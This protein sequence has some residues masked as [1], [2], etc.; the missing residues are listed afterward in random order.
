MGSFKIIR[1]TGKN[2]LRKSV[3]SDIF[4]TQTNA[5]FSKR[6]FY[7]V[8]NHIKF[9]AEID[10]LKRYH[11]MRTENNTEY[12]AFTKNN[13][14]IDETIYPEVYS[15][16]RFAW[17][18]MNENHVMQKKMIDDT[19]LQL[20]LNSIFDEKELK[21]VLGENYY[22][23]YGQTDKEFIPFVNFSKRRG[24]IKELA[25]QIKEFRSSNITVQDLKEIV[26]DEQSMLNSLE[27]KKKIRNLTLVLAFVDE[28]LKQ[29]NCILDC[30]LLDQFNQLLQSQ[31][32]EL[33]KNSLIYL[34]GFDD[35]TQAEINIIRQLIQK[36]TQV[37]LAQLHGQTNQAQNP[38]Y[39]FHKPDKMLAKIGMKAD[40]YEKS[41]DLKKR[42]TIQEYIE[43]AWRQLESDELANEELTP[44]Q[45]T[46]YEDVFFCKAS[47]K[48]AEIEMVARTIIKN[49]SKENAPE[50]IRYKDILIISSDLESY[51]NIIKPIFNRYK[52]PVFLDQ[53][54]SMH[55]HP[56]A[57]MMLGLF[58][59]YLYSYENL[60]RIFKTALIRPTD[61]NRSEF[62]DALDWLENYLLANN[63][64]KK[65]WQESFNYYRD[66]DEDGLEE[67]DQLVNEKINR[68]RVFIVDVLESFSNLLK[69]KSNRD[70]ANQLYKWILSYGILDNIILSEEQKEYEATNSEDA[71]I[72]NMVLQGRDIWNTFVKVLDQVVLL[73][74]DSSFKKEEFSVLLQTGFEAATF[75]SIPETLDS[76]QCSAMSIDQKQDY[77]LTFVIGTTAANLPK[78][79][80]NK[81]ILTDIDK[82]KLNGTINNK[83][84]KDTS[85]YQQSIENF[86]FYKTL[87]TTSKKIVFSYP[88]LAEDGSLNEISPFI[89]RLKKKLEFLA[90]YNWDFESALDHPLSDAN[91]VDFALLVD[92]SYNVKSFLSHA[93]SL[94]RS[95]DGLFASSM[96]KSFFE[97]EIGSVISNYMFKAYSNTVVP[98]NP[99][100]V[101]EMLG[102]KYQTSISALEAFNKNP[103]EFYLKYILKIKSREE[104]RLDSALEGTYYH[105]GLEKLVKQKIN[106]EKSLLNYYDYLNDLVSENNALKILNSSQRYLAQKQEFIANIVGVHKLLAEYFT[107]LK[108]T[109]FEDSSIGAEINFGNFGK[110]VNHLKA[111]P[112]TD[113]MSLRG[114]IDRLDKLHY[115]DSS[116]ADSDIILD[117]KT[118]GKNFS[119]TKALKGLDLQLLSYWNA[120]AN[121]DLQTNVQAA[122]FVPIKTGTIN[123]EDITPGRSK[124][125]KYEAQNGNSLNDAIFEQLFNHN[126]NFAIEEY[127]MAKNKISGLYL[128]SGDKEYDEAVKKIYSYPLF[129]QNATVTL[130]T[131]EKTKSAETTETEFSELQTAV[132]E[133]IKQNSENIQNGIYPIAPYRDKEETG[134]KYSDFID[135][136]RFSIDPS[137][138]NLIKNDDNIWIPHY[139]DLEDKD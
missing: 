131:G 100:F 83:Y 133:V 61:M 52:I 96:L 27:L 29:E 77:K 46:D 58:D 136:M 11:D 84:L 7:L 48:E 104:Q 134:I 121:K 117:Y 15:I 50:G 34:D 79:R 68:L 39:L 71:L 57:E 90:D 110:N 125:F 102:N 43:Y 54:Q 98:V 123:L 120:L 28:K 91:T 55:T 122:F 78:D 115:K 88:V 74:A 45:K 69:A 20:I 119:K 38:G 130:P 132:L 64:Q 92:Y 8:P 93:M 16:S 4:K 32:D 26:E 2:D 137:L 85:K 21:K 3:I 81:D 80:K 114:K 109:N 128:L 126:D 101:H 95:N 107:Y 127:R 49:I 36:S 76:V 66:I 51:A 53:K 73:Y 67:S 94:F 63:P 23:E 1:G 42:S 72:Q 113:W 87:L 108:V 112:V 135:I 75:S 47:S 44:I 18:L 24:F 9:S 30:E 60:M 116:L 12:V 31:G 40:V 82:E 6:I 89:D 5:D 14:K 106:Q 37:T 86:S 138:D 33:L 65:D 105:L 103:Y 59:D 129:K 19:G 22:L 56:F 118:N 97:E 111:L 62:F 99:D 124:E 70:F 41:E 17:T 13:I 139:N 35:F 25:R 10:V